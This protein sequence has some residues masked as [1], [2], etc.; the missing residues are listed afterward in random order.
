M[1]SIV[2]EPLEVQT[3]NDSKSKRRRRAKKNKSSES[4][5]DSKSQTDSLSSSGG[6]QTTVIDNGEEVK[7]AQPETI[8]KA[9]VPQVVEES[10]PPG[11]KEPESAAP[12]ENEPECPVLDKKTIE[13]EVVTQT[14]KDEIAAPKE[15]Q[16]NVI[17]S[18]IVKDR[19]NA[20]QKV[21][22]ELAMA[23]EPLINLTPPTTP[24]VTLEIKKEGKD[25]NVTPNLMDESIIS[26]IDSPPQA[27]HPP[28]DSTFSPVVDTSI[29]DSRPTIDELNLTPSVPVKL[30]HRTST[31]LVQ[32]VLM[33]AGG[34]G[35]PKRLNTP[36]L[37]MPVLSSLAKTP[38]FSQKFQSE[39]TDEDVFGEEPVRPVNLLEKSILKSSRRKR[40]MSVADAES[41]IQKRVMFISPQ[42]MEIGT[43]DERMMASF[44]EEREMSIIRQAAPGS[45]RRKRSLSTGTP[46]KTNKTPLKTT[47]E[48]PSRSKKMPDFKAI[49]QKEFE[50]MESLAEHQARKNE[51][52]KK[53]VT[54]E[55][56]KSKLPQAS[57]IPTV[58]SRKPLINT[59]SADN[60]LQ[61]GGRSRLLKRSQS[62]N[63]EEPA[64]KRVQLVPP[65]TS[66]A[67]S[68]SN[69]AKK[70]AVVSGLQ[71]TKSE[72]TAAWS[73]PIP[74]VASFLGTKKPTMTKPDQKA[75]QVNR[76]KIEERREK[77]MSLY[78]TNQVQKTVTE[79]RQKNENMLKGVRLNRR[80]ELQMQHR[81]DHDEA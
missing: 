45:A 56:K 43:I 37:S 77:N 18:E 66:N 20:E 49:H 15:K 17:A 57:K 2:S 68:T 5:E 52:A 46:L 22:E 10:A 64:K 29:H 55:V 28:P 16:E 30:S 42:V 39:E 65:V 41:M 63:D 80:F 61:N 21:V 25:M 38:K 3:S 58:L 6:D 76:S 40:S 71:R 50:R 73:A 31:P 44:M 78:K 62:A 4:V 8:S 59:A 51:R 24:A 34:C 13:A 7:N 19:A 36:K 11:E 26:V 67:A 53:L 35:T 81:R 32:K 54:P 75:P 47:Q 60:L 33:N 70:I 12:Q 72:S 23:Q 74:T 48:R 1:P 79:K 69:Q 14:K 9:P 27:Q